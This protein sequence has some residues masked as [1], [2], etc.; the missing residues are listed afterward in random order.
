MRG[1]QA[2][3][4][5]VGDRGGEL[6]EGD[7]INSLHGGSSLCGAA[8]TNRTSNHKVVVRSLALLGGLR[9]QKGSGVALSC[10][11]G[12][13]H[14]WDLALLWPRLVA[15]ALIGPLAWEPPYAAGVA[16]RG[17]KRKAVSMANPKA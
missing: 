1:S 15:V 10:G 16:L 14:C 7:V 5:G 3:G 11:A 9:I 12:H 4:E 17:E 8:K 13:R 6:L 2:L